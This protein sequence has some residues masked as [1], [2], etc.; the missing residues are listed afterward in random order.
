MGDTETLPRPYL[1]RVNLTGFTAALGYFG[2]YTLTRIGFIYSAGRG[3]ATLPADD[4]AR[5]LEQEQRYVKVN[6]FQ[7]FLYVFVGS[8]FRF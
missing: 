1:P 7:S 5:L 2:E 3:E 8:T 4:E 6:Q